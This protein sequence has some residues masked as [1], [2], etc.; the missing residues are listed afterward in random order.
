MAFIKLQ[1][2]KTYV[3]AWNRMHRKGELCVLQVVAPVMD[4]VQVQFTRD[5]HQAITSGKALRE[6]PKNYQTPDVRLFQ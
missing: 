2:G 6:V 5:G 1:V 4:S 3:Y